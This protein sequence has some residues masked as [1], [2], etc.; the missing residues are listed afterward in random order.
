MSRKRA[1]DTDEP[2]V[3]HYVAV[4]ERRSTK[5]TWRYEDDDFY[6]LKVRIV[7]DFHL[8]DVPLGL[9]VCKCVPNS[10]KIETEDYMFELVVS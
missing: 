5:D 7:R 9:L 1:L 6:R 8:I 4:I 3:T 2:K 10:Q